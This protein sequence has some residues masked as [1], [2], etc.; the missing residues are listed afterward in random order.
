[1]TQSYSIKP[2]LDNA[3]ARVRRAKQHLVNLRRRNNRLWEPQPITLFGPRIPAIPPIFGI[4]IGETVYNLRAALDY[5][6]YEV[7]FLDSGSI[8]KGTRFP[9]EDTP[10]G[11][12]GRRKTYLKGVSHKHQTL[13]ERLQ[14]YKG[15]NWTQILRDVSNPDKHKNLTVIRPSGHLLRRRAISIAL[16]FL[17]L[18]MH[19]DANLASQ[20][21]FGD[22]TL[23]IETLEI[24][25]SQVSK[26]ID[27]FNPEF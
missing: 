11:F 3:Y 26:V 16:P 22:G 25:Q 7:A 14:P 13:I 4:L 6:I 24:L 8:Q 27:S 2:S 23:V 19:V 10:S 15:V 17:L 5:L 1:M 20:I 18:P 21:K 9:I 12:N